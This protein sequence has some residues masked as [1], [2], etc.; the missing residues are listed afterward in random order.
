MNK[1]FTRE[2]G[3]VVAIS[4][5]KTNEKVREDRRKSAGVNYTVFKQ[6]LL[7]VYNIF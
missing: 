5:L 7:L 1:E 6:H 4:H 3:Q 2:D